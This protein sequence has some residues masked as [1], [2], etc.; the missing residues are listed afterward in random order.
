MNFRNF[1]H[2]F[3]T[4]SQR[5]LCSAIVA[6][7][8]LFPLT[9]GTPHPPACATFA[10]DRSHLSLFLSSMSKF[11]RSIAVF[12]TEPSPPSP[13]EKF[14]RDRLFVVD[15]GSSLRFTA[16]LVIYSPSTNRPHAPSSRSSIDRLSLSFVIK[17]SFEIISQTN[18]FFQP[19]GRRD[20]SPFPIYSSSQS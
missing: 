2:Y 5:H 6:I 13:F 18:M 8:V 20:R 4:R 7:A 9:P 15:I 16:V 10:T 1:F 14:R 17:M 3:S 19:T 12:S 11:S